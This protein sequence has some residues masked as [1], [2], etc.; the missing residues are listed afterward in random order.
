MWKSRFNILFAFLLPLIAACSPQTSVTFPHIHGL[1]FSA[2]GQQLIVPAHDGLRIYSDGTWEIPAVPVRD[3]MGYSS[4]DV[5]FYSSGHPGP[6]SAEINPLGLITSLDNGQ[7][8]TRL[9]FEGQS[10]F[11]LMGVG[12]ES[13]VIYVVNQYPNSTMGEGLYYS[14]DDGETWVSSAASGLTA[15]PWQIAVHPTETGTLALATDA[16]LFFSEDFGQT[17]SL[18]SDVGPVSSVSF[19][20]DG[21]TLLFGSSSLWRYELSSAQTR[22]ITVPAMAQDEFILYITGSVASQ[23]AI[24]TTELNIYISQDDGLTWTQIADQGHG[25]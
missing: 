3:Y 9:G 24:A 10:D 7:N 25:I 22:S 1:G 20:P 12:Y 23:I 14:L 17:V 11:H 13:H 21:E 4:V 18:V 6:G 8:L 19:D 2:D 16:G 15:Y 5:G